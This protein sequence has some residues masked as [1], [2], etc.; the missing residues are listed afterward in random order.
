MKYRPGFL[1]IVLCFWM[2]GMY[3][4]AKVSSEVGI[5]FSTLGLLVMIVHVRHINAEKTIF[6]QIFLYSMP[7]SLAIFCSFSFLSP[8]L[9]FRELVEEHQWLWHWAAISLPLAGLLY[10]SD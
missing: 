1:L 5:V 4:L 2:T 10:P 6:Y 7:V 8:S 9:S 3:I